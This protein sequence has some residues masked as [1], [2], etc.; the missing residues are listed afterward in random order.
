MQ[1]LTQANETANIRSIGQLQSGLEQLVVEGQTW[2]HH[3]TKEETK[4]RKGII[5]D[6]GNAINEFVGRYDALVDA[7]LESYAESINKCAA[8]VDLVLK[9]LTDRLILLQHPIEA[10][11]VDVQRPS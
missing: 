8:H 3:A 2:E 10:P 6:L 7:A 5:T 11:T 9:A 4:R 1:Q